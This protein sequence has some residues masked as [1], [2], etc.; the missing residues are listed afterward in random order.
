M[1]LSYDTPLPILRLQ[2][3]LLVI[4]GVGALIAAGQIIILPESAFCELHV[5]KVICAL[6]PNDLPHGQEEEQ[7]PA[8]SFVGTRTISATSISLQDHHPVRLAQPN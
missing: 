8:K 4:L 3:G 1:L 6:E 5:A 7:S 2:R